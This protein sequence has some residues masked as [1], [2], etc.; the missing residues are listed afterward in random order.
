VICTEYHPVSSEEITND[1]DLFDANTPPSTTDR[2][3]FS[4]NTNAI[5]EVAIG[6]AADTEEDMGPD[7]DTA[8]EAQLDGELLG[9]YPEGEHDDGSKVVKSMTERVV[10]DEVEVGEG[11]ATPRLH[12]ETCETP[13][14]FQAGCVWTKPDWS[15]AY[16]VVFMAFFTIY[17]QSSPNWRVDW[18]RQSPE[19]T[20]QLADN[21]DLL[22]ET[23]NS[24]E[25]SPK[26]LSM[27]F[28]RLRDQF[29]DQL[30]SLNSHMFPRRGQ[31]PTSVCAILEL[32]FGS[33][34]GPGIKQQLSCTSCGATSQACRNFSLLA[35]PM[36]SED[37]RR[38]TDPRFIP[39]AVLLARFV[40]SLAV[41]PRS[42]LCGACH[43]S[44]QVQSLAMANSPWIW[45]ETN[46]DD[47][48]S[49][50]PTV[51]IELPGQHLAYDLHS[52]VYL[53]A[54]HFTVRMRDPSGGWWNYDGMW[55]YGA[56]QRDHI[57]TET[58][59]LHNGGRSAVFLIYRRSDH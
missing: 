35:L 25:Y 36:F 22:L 59:L 58:D 6:D 30:S 57:Q 17:W 5:V 2:H 7:P 46:S 23:A 19:W 51:Q 45:F 26:D 47:T 39:S 43:G 12:R 49:P 21:F 34:H 38:E 20:P 48:V 32:L 9:Y 4:S 42:S 28:S 29:R 11:V 13:H 33:T 27:L 40:E 3:R 37:C 1:A 54:D 18:R 56:P 24:P 15:C 31:I 52:V 55:R 53:G 41:P 14:P 16:D 44:T 10:A 50:S 8:E